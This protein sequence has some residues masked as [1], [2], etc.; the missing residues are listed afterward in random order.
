MEAIQVVTVPLTGVKFATAH[1]DIIV[2]PEPV[3]ATAAL[4]SAFAQIVPDLESLPAGRAADQQKQVIRI[5]DRHVIAQFL[6]ESQA[7]ATPSIAP[8]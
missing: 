2:D 5:W 4:D 1:D 7:I 8:I 6:R 3:F